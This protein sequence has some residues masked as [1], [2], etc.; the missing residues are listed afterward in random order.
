MTKKVL[1]LILWTRLPWRVGLLLA[2]LLS[3]LFGLLAPYF[4]KEFVDHLTGMP[5]TFEIPQLIGATSYLLI[6]LAF[7]SLLLS[8]VFNQLTNFLGAREA[9]IS[10]RELAQ[11]IYEKT[12]SLKID[13]LSSRPV[14]EIVSLYA[15]DVPGST[16]LLEQTLP[17]GSTT[18]FPLLLAPVA[19]SVLLKTSILPTV[20]IMLA[21]SFVNTAL[22]FR[23]SKFF[24][25][26]KQLAAERIGLV[27]EW[28]TQL[29]GLRILGWIEAFEDK[30]YLKREVETQNRIEMVTNG[31]TMNSISS[32]MTFAM[33]IIALGTMTVWQNTTPSSGEILASLWILGVF[34]TRPFRQMPWF[35]T[36][37]FD[38]WTSIKRIDEFLSLENLNSLPPP[39]KTLST[40]RNGPNHESE[41]EK[42][43]PG[44]MKTPGLAL[45]VTGL[46]LQRQGEPPLLNNLS[47]E[48]R[49]GEFVAF[50]GEVGSGKSLFFLSLLRETGAHF[51]TFE[52][53]G[54]SVLGMPPSEI[55][56]YFSFVPQESFIM[57]ATLAQN[58]FFDYR[59]QIDDS[60]LVTQ[61]LLDSQF[62]FSKER[63]PQGLQ[64]DLGERGVNLSG[65]QKLRI[66]LAR[67][68][69]KDGEIL[70]IDDGFSNLDVKTE[71]ALL[72]SLFF[73]RWKHRTK[74]LATHRLSVLPFT[75]RVVFMKKGRIISEG[76]Y[77]DLLENHSE[78]R[79]F[80]QSL[81]NPES[82]PH[83]Q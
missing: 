59:P 51:E 52:I 37:A 20:L 28:I 29:R 36:F 3:S 30:I 5:S 72:K 62:E 12:L 50:V 65:G 46:H 61:A 55:K 83:A 82:E 24:F 77:L 43:Q 81:A 44:Q 13:S 60:T 75:D 40:H 2:S 18:F 64:T 45:A 57:S 32:S 70:L 14:G 76:R 66:S 49:A 22:A 67:A 6:A 11:K 17:Q 26:Y 47:F 73:G 79:A 15:T 31:Q 80:V 23:Q 1:P 63:L 78:F 35:F 27:N 42:R 7:A 48:I 58:V 39:T 34:L 69:A 10:Q 71:A 41:I 25:R 54:R 38:S 68:A 8:Q 56:K 19:L 74:I 53:D 4:Q 33:N 9:L 16:I 21:V